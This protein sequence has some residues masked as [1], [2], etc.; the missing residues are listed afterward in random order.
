MTE[1]FDA[2][3]NSKTEED[4]K[5]A[6]AGYFDIPYNTSDRHDLYTAQVLFEFKFDK[7]FRNVKNLAAVIAQT[8]Y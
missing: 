6:Y 3:K 2:L 8:L 1:L 4:V 5:H 7:D